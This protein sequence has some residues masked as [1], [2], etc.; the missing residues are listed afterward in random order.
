MNLGDWTCRC[1]EI[2]FRNRDKCRKCRLLK[3]QLS[4]NV[5]DYSTSNSKPDYEPRD[6]DWQCS[7]GFSNFK[8]RS[9]CHKCSLQKNAPTAT[10]NITSTTST[11]S[12]TNSSKPEY[13]YEDG[14]WKCKCN[15]MNFKTRSACSKC[16]VKKDDL[17]VAANSDHELN[18]LVCVI[19]L[20]NQRSIAIMTCKHLVCCEDCVKY[21]TNRKCPVCRTDYR[22]SDLVKMFI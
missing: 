4:Q 19:C 12:V 13:K 9:N 21:I 3:S 11:T 14:D 6:G 18:P 20:T 16:G 15:Y 22:A 10:T 17:I 2:N 7:C 1:G 8:T 5:G